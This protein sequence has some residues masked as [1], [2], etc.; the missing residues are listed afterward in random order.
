[1]KDKD[2]GNDTSLKDEHW[3]NAYFSILF[4]KGGYAI[5]CSDLH[6]SNE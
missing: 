2:D 1:M 3:L 4:K 6:S 5:C